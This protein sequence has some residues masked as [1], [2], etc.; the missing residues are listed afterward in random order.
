MVHLGRRR[1]TVVVLVL[2]FIGTGC[3]HRVVPSGDSPLRYR[4]LVFANVVKTTGVQYGAAPDQAGQMVNLLLDVYSPAGDTATSRPAIVWVHGGGFSSGTRTSSE[5]VDEATTF[6][7]KGYVNVSISY[8]LTPGGC[9]AGDPTPEC[10]TG[11]LDAQHDAQAA[12]RFL[13]ANAATYGVDPTRIG[14]AGTSAGAITALNVAYNST[15]VGTSGNPEQSSAVRAAVSLS[16][17]KIFGAYDIGDAPTL[18]FHGSND[19]IVPYQWAVNTVNDAKAAGLT[20]ALETWE[21]AGHVP[22]EQFRQQI[23]DQTSNF[24]YWQLDVVQAA[25]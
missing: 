25:G 13:R 3:L 8:R 6:A 7:K 17:A 10:I 21:G 18:L 5:I 14:I 2:A 4:D 1:L 22:Y 11:I 20:S 23:L 12:V 19:V 9:S 24:F 16:G 15:D